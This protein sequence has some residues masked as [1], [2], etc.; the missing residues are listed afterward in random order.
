MVVVDRDGDADDVVLMVLCTPR[1]YFLL[2]L[3][4][5]LRPSLSGMYRNETGDTQSDWHKL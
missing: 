5:D 3:L 2:L 4:P 1:V